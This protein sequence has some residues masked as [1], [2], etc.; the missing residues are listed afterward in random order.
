MSFSN[1]INND[2]TLSKT[3]NCCTIRKTTNKIKS[4]VFEDKRSHHGYVNEKITHGFVKQNCLK[5]AITVG[6]LSLSH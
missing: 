6:G 5:K 4:K 2:K 3:Q 1:F